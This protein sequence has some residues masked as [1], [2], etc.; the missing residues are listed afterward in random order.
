ML[1]YPVKIYDRVFH[2]VGLVDNNIGKQN[3]AY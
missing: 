1:W 3:A 2:K